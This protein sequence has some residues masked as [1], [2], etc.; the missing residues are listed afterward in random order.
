MNSPARPERQTLRD[1]KRLHALRRTGLLDT[2]PEPSFDR[3]TRL[4]TRL[5]GVPVALVSLVDD[6]RQFFK[7]AQGLSAPWCDTRE[8]PLSHSF[9]QHVVTATEKL[10]IDDAANHPL[11]ADNKAV[12]E[13]GVAAYAGIPLVLRSGETLGS[14][15]AIDTVVR[16]WKAEEIS[17]LE[18][19]A[20]SVVSEIELRALA[21][22]AQEMTRQV[23]LK[24]Q[25]RLALLDALT[26]GIYGIDLSGSCTFINRAGA[27]M[28]GYSPQEVIGR[29]MHLLIHH[30]RE[31][32]APYPEDQCPIVQARNRGCGVDE[33]CEPFWRRDG[34]AFMAR[35]SSQ[36]I[37][38]R[39]ELKGV[40]VSFTDVSTRLLAER[41]MVMQ[42]AVSRVLAESDTFD[43][44]LPLFL[45]AVGEGLGWDVGVAWSP[46][47]GGKLSSRATWIRENYAAEA[48]LD[49][50]T[51]VCLA[52]GEG[53]AGQVWESG[54][55]RWVQ[56]I[57]TAPYL[58]NVDED[59]PDCV[60][61]AFA[62]PIRTNRDV[63]GVIEFFSRSIMAPDEELM[64]AVAT[65]GNQIGQFLERKR[66]EEALW[67]ANRGLD[68][69]AVGITISDARK[70][71]YPIVYVNPAFSLI[72][73]Y[74]SSEALGHN[75]RF[76]QGADTDADILAELRSALREHRE[77]HVTLLNYRKDG[78]PFWN[79]LTISPVRDPGGQLTHFIGIQND[80]TA[81]RLAHEALRERDYLLQAIFRSIS[82]QVAV[83][84]RA[85][86]IAYVSQSWIRFAEENARDPAGVGVGSNYLR[87]CEKASPKS[88]DA[89]RA[90]AGL[91]SVMEGMASHFSMEYPCHAPAEERWFE[92]HI[93]A[94]PSEHG[95]AVVTH[96]NITERKRAEQALNAA[97]LAAEAADRAKS[98]FLAN[99]SHELR[100][101]LNAIISYSE[102]VQEECEDLG[103][104]QFLPDL[105]KIGSSARHLLTLINSVLDLAKIEAG[106]LELY[107]EIF[108]V[109]S[110]LGSVVDAVAP[111]IA[112]RGNRLELSCESDVGTLHSD[113]TKV[114]QTLLNLLSNAAKFTENGTVS[115]RARREIDGGQSWIVFE[116]S[117][118]GIGM[119]EAQARQLFQPFVQA[120]P[121]TT[122]KYGGTG[123]GLD[124]SRRFC[125]ALGGDISLTSAPGKGSTFTVKLPDD[126]TEVASEPRADEL[127]AAARSRPA[128]ALVIE[129][130]PATREFLG[131]LLA[132]EGLR[133]LTAA[134]GE[135]GL[136]L[137]A[138]DPPDLVTVDLH[139]P[140]V[141]GW[142]FISRFKSDPAGAEVPVFVISV[143]EQ[144]SAAYALGASEYLVK[145]VDR[146][147][148]ATL[149]R[150]YC[151]SKLHP[152][153]LVVDDDETTRKSLRAN[154]ESEGWTV[155]E[156]ADGCA[157]LR[158]LETGGLPD[159]ILLDLIMPQMDGFKLLEALRTDSA[160]AS[161]P[162]IVITAKDLTNE[163]RARLDGSVQ[164]LITKSGRSTVD[165]LAEIRR[166]LRL[167][168]MQHISADS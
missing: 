85:G 53:V 25:E 82:A 41:R 151:G 61:A 138:Q 137:A 73:G 108:E 160:N 37:L 20:A 70:P 152:V 19:L 112:K 16:H 12:T 2:G 133:V 166:T 156:A 39:G 57:A 167:R 10:I 32:G 132:R 120:D 142:T 88:P 140:C 130:D 97:R 30:T 129:D 165:L 145:P 65:V 51:G 168:G 154:L 159:L 62:F 139:M 13:L 148:F 116:V 99:M 121:S 103:V 136:Q 6:H 66:A 15:C 90:H 115:L 27:A 31:D 107:L 84:D 119:T 102:L 38:L 44:A 75:C 89:A 106:K 155:R 117:D 4:A 52:K 125:R 54:R 163:E 124:I 94:M 80:V 14:F 141:D 7:S 55:P 11:V 110:L 162:V 23:E 59:L 153:A 40:L 18:D 77:S 146:R 58:A 109:E 67:L 43:A 105:Q 45:R 161:I 101:P 47:P 22:E 164:G 72:T 114:R 104:V 9:C 149:L 28:L 96:I 46:D 91:T 35:Y 17:I 81:E 63:L 150:R 135:E 131:K 92:M 69:S 93:D 60:Q 126:R 50:I 144:R 8:T 36:P 98:Q 127:R 111:L 122:R 71:D 147:V 95:G 29:N 83:I 86:S 5:L 26:E 49:R 128:T 33:Q 143:D 34:T 56:D 134:D 3:I 76:L 123:L 24:S 78:T 42:H 158:A 157:A 21:S 48:L 74:E 100:T 113:L 118:T 79:E 1:S 87:V 68:S 64:R